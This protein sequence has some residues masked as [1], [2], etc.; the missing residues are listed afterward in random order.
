M[1]E[2]QAEEC[3]ERSKHD[4]GEDWCAIYESYQRKRYQMIERVNLVIQMKAKLEVKYDAKVCS[5]FSR[6]DEG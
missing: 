2:Q 3:K 1:V 6:A 4:W 5:L